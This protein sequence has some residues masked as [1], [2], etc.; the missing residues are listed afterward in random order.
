[1]KANA[2][3]GACAPWFRQR[4]AIRPFMPGYVETWDQ[5][6]SSAIRVTS[7]ILTLPAGLYC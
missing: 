4:Q 2:S 3:V 5:G 6:R 1:M 7:S